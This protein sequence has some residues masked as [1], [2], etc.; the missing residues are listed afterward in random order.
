MSTYSIICYKGGDL[1][2]RFHSL[3]YSKWKRSNRHGNDW[4]KLVA[5][6]AYY[7]AYERY[8]D[9]LLSKPGSIVRLA[10]LSNDKDNVLGFSVCRENVLDY[11]YVHKDHRK[12]GIGT[13]L[14]PYGTTIFTHLT[15]TAR[16]IWKTK[17]KYKH[18]KFNPFA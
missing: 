8:I 3:I 6:E 5:Y 10:V 1:P 12:Q 15:Y 13:S 16:F 14:F 9:V 17:E 11:I 7:P 2:Q 18:L 4:W